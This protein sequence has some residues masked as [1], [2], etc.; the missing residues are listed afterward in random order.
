MKNLKPKFMLTRV[1][2]DGSQDEPE[3]APL[4]QAIEEAKMNR[5]GFFGAGLTA[6]ALTMLDSCKT[7]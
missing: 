6:A 7:A 4:S 2:N 5:R 3:I 1:Y